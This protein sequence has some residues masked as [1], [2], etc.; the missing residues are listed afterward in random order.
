MPPLK[1]SQK[2]ILALAIGQA[3]TSS[4]S[5]ADVLVTSNTDDGVNCTLREALQAIEIRSDNAGCINS[6]TD[7]YG[8]NDRIVFEETGVITLEDGELIVSSDVTIDASIVSGVTI[9]AQQDSR[10]MNVYGYKYLNLK[11]MTLTGGLASRATADDSSYP[12][13]GAILGGEGSSITIENSTITGNSSTSDGGAI[14]LVDA[15]SLDLK[16]SLLTDNRSGSYGGAVAGEGRDVNITITNSRFSG[17]YADGGGAIANQN[18]RSNTDPSTTTIVNSQINNN[19]ARVYGGGVLLDGAYSGDTMHG[20]I[21]NSTISN[22]TVSGNSGAYG[23]GIEVEK[24]ILTVSGSTVSG[25]SVYYAYFSGGVGGGIY[26]DDSDI[27]ISNS[28]ISGNF[29]NGRGGGIFLNDD[30]TL[31]LNNATVVSNRA[32]LGV[33]GV[34]SENTITLYNSIL[35]NSLGGGRLRRDRRHVRHT[36]YH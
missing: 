30:S 36:K 21:Q 14:A 9:D 13:G 15:A 6:G 7:D 3:I 31:V 2:N 34:L 27:T 29:T 28:T 20:S 12:S 35:A 11:H 16:N 33:G 26:S 32:E 18:F 24:T 5:A 22:N 1:S 25:N 23:G 8:I 17:N 10:V 4:A 19:S